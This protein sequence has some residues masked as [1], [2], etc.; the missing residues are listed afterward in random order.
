MTEA[1]PYCHEAIDQ[2]QLVQQCLDAKEDGQI[3]WLQV[4]RAIE[5]HPALASHTCTVTGLKK[6][7]GT[8]LSVVQ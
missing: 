6:H 8:H 7:V 4:K 2:T 5:E 1:C 3:Q